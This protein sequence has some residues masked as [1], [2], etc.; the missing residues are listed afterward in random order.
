MRTVLSHRHGRQALLPDAEPGRRAPLVLG[1]S[2]HNQLRVAVSSFGG[3]EKHPHMAHPRR[4]RRRVT[5]LA[6]LAAAPQNVGLLHYKSL[7]LRRDR[8]TRGRRNIPLR[9]SRRRQGSS[10]RSPRRSSSQS[11]APHST[12][13]STSLAYPSSAASS[14]TR[15]TLHAA[16]RSPGFFLLH[17]HHDGTHTGGSCTTAA[18]RSLGS[19]TGAAIS[20]RHALPAISVDCEVAV[21]V[22]AGAVVIMDSLPMVRI[23]ACTCRM[24]NVLQCPMCKQDF[25]PTTQIRPAATTAT[26]LVAGGWNRERKEAM[27]DGDVGALGVDVHVAVACDGAMEEPDA[28]WGYGRHGHRHGHRLIAGLGE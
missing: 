27:D 1:W 7:M 15:P 8:T 16:L 2:R 23:T 28:G 9:G 19:C 24:Y 18:P 3:D 6:P 26:G 22:S 14:T 4:R 17:P 5:V 12:R 21:H 20:P 13:P 25:E 11:A 10:S